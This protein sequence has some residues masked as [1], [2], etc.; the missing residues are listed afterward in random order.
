[1][2][3]GK[4]NSCVFLDPGRLNAQMVEWYPD[5]SVK[6]MCIAMHKAHEDSKKYILLP[7]HQG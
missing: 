2:V 7:Y 4:V 1:M 3:K 6:Y 5:V